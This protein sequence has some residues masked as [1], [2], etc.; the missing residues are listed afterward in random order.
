MFTLMPT[1]FETFLVFGIFLKLGTPLIAIVTIVSVIF[2]VWFTKVVTER[3]I[4]E[5]RA[6]TNADNAVKGA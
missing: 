4:R 3:R 2:Y 5:R 6:M 1:L